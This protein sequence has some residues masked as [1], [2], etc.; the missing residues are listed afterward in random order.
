M[1]LPFDL[2]PLENLATSLM[3]QTCTITRDTNGADDDTLDQTTGLLTPV[4]DQTVV[5]VGVCSVTFVKTLRQTGAEE[6]GGRQLAP[7]RFE[8]GI[9]LDA[10]LPLG[11]PRLGDLCEINTS[12]SDQGLVGKRFKVETVSAATLAVRRQMLCVDVW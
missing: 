3:V 8:V 4:D 1:T 9:P 6:E 7:S 5:Y 2:S 11:L 12:G 10:T